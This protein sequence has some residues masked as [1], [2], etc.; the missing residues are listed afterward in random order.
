MAADFSVRVMTDQYDPDKLCAEH[1]CAQWRC[2]IEH[3]PARCP[4]WLKGLCPE[5]EDQLN[6]KQL[7]ALDVVRAAW[8]M[9][10]TNV[11]LSNC[12]H[13]I[14]DTTISTIGAVI[15]IHSSPIIEQYALALMRK[16]LAK[17]A[18]DGRPI[19]DAT[20]MDE[21]W[22]RVVAATEVVRHFHDVAMVQELSEVR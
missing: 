18:S 15:F 16:I 5:H 1:G 22:A 19:A 10:W 11:T 2:A 7:A 3:V 8:R 20:M 13:V 14:L 6:E 21:I 12:D 17:P 9:F 4:H